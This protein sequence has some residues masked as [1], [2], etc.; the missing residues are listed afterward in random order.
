M[1]L[2]STLPRTRNPCRN[3]SN[4]GEGVPGAPAEK[5]NPIRE[6]GCCARPRWEEAS[7][8]IPTVKM[9]IL[10]FTGVFVVFLSSLT[11][12]C[13]DINLRQGSRAQHTDSKHTMGDPSVPSVFCDSI[14]QIDAG[15]F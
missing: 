9:R 13:L 6:T 5:M 11:A 15:N 4:A 1:F 2:P 10:I 3:A 12:P 8:K 7:M 14:R